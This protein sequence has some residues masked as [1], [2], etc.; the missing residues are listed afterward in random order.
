MAMTFQSRI[1]DNR[2]QHLRVVTDGWSNLTTGHRTTRDKVT[3]TQ[4]DP[5]APSTDCQR[6]EDIY[7]G[8]DL[9]S[10]IVDEL[11]DEMLRKW[12]RLQVTMR[13]DAEAAENIEAADEMMTALDD[14]GAAAK[15]SEALT[16]AQVLGGA[17]IFVGADDGGGDDLEAMAQP[18]RENAI[19]SIKFLDV[20]DRWDVEIES[21]YGDPLEKNYG[22]P[23]TY[24][25]RQSGSV[26]GAV[27][28]PEMIIHETRV[29]RF[30]GVR[31]NKRRLLRNNGWHDPVYVRIE[32]EL[33]DFGLSWGSVVHL[34]ADFAPMIFTSPGLDRS[35]R[36]DGGGT[37]MD[38]LT[39]MDV[40]RSTVRMVPI[41]KDETLERKATPLAGL[42][43]TLA[44]LMLRICAAARMPITKL[45]GQS[46]SGLNTTA[47]GDLTFWYDRVEGHQRKDLRKQL[48]RLVNLLWMA[49]DGPTNGVEPKSWSLEFESLWQMSQDEEA[50]ARKT[51]ADTDQAYIDSGV[52]EPEEVAM[53]R[54]GGDRYNF[55]TKLNMEMRAE[56]E[57]EPE[58]EPPA[59]PFPAQPLAVPPGPQPP[60]EPTSSTDPADDD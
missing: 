47:E 16:W 51:Q 40:C 9:G 30:D 49:K 59:M 38:R 11:V 19:R 46:P 39:Q 20:Y 7:H 10:R 3:A 33:A 35:L 14:L 13:D 18:L 42:P 22:Q 55:E 24:R 36:M 53:S 57:A 6:F 44:L 12:F 54:F 43:D 37:M 5:V 27:A 48:T 26:R 50:T 29:I 41:D 2:G 4:I 23:E 1:V 21:E 8:D 58:P 34:L 56:L 60:F 52:L 17:V 25:V 45:F 15:I 28:L 31:V 32:E